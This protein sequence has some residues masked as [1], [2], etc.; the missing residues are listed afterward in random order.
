MSAYGLGLVLDVG[1]GALLAYA[2]SDLYR[3]VRRSRL[4]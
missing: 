2:A 4:D 3:I 1:L